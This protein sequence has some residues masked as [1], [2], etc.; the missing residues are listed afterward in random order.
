M[1]FL[2]LKKNNFHNNKE[3]IHKNNN[4]INFETIE[5]KNLNFKYE[6][7]KSK[8]LNDFNFKIKKGELV[9]LFG[10]TGKGKSTFL[11]VFWDFTKS[12][13]VKF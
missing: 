7:S 2:I 9:A 11:D 13:Q 12:L 3:Q 10:E 5:F 8:I 1:K 4:L 6:K